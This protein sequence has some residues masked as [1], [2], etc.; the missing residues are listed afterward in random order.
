[1]EIVISEF[2][3]QAAVDGLAARFDV[4]YAPDLVDQPEALGE[5][6]ADAR[7]LIVRNRTQVRQ[8]LLDHAP[9]LEVVG[10]LGVG[11]DNI[12][13]EAC[14]QRGVRVYPATGANDVAV[15]EYVIAA[16][17]LLARGAYAVTDQLVAGD[18]P[19]QAC[20][21]REVYGQVMG[22]IGCGGIAR[23]TARRARAMGMIVIAHDPYV[24]A[25]DE[26]WADIGRIG[27]VEELLEAADIISLHVPLTED[28]RNLIDADALSR[29]KPGALLINTARGGV[30]DETALIEA[31]RRGQ[32][33]GAALDV[34]A[35]EPLGE[36]SGSL[37]AGVPNLLLTPHIA[38]VTVQSNVRV[39]SMIADRV[40]Q[41]LLGVK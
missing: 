7:A 2:M 34:F 13:L 39:S 23:E 10:R 24:A 22:L 35:D 40:A 26:V 3:D 8:T 27:T 11:L 6:L 12:D 1:M 21:G 17:M 37:F 9:Q 41:H 36:E 14:E 38:G 20:I 30:V 33:A 28:T 32:V 29:I 4:L 19:R 25:D 16:A 31:I 15:A 5:A 18:W